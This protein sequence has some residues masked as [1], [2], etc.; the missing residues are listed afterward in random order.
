M[1]LR[2]LRYFVAVAEELHFRRAAERL[3]IAQPP[4]SQQIQALEAE[5]GAQLFLR[6]RRSVSLTDAGQVFLQRARRILAEADAAGKEARRMALGE[7]GELRVG[8][9]ASLP[10]TEMFPRILSAFHAVCPD[11]G[12]RLQ[13][14]FTRD[15]LEALRT[16]ALDV[17][18]AR[19]N[20]TEARVDGLHFRLLRNDPLVMAMPV[21]HPLAD[22]PRVS[23]VQFAQEPFIMY[24]ETSGA[25]LGGLLRRL[26]ANAGF[27]PHIGQEAAEAVTQIGLV[28]A[29]L[30]VT[31]M[32][33]PMACIAMDRVRYVPLTDKGAYHSMFLVTREGDNKPQ[34]ARFLACVEGVGE[35]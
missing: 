11:V 25:D 24:P 12:V 5:L 20:A 15:Q 28:A 14:M 32:P 34:L 33:L 8:Y 27:T 30:G 2:H 18:F 22:A 6:S 7:I 31:A 10:L 16:D 23:L 13:E 9:T 29:G 21:R 19:Y 35:V 3:C 26:C 4:L 17:G 1:E